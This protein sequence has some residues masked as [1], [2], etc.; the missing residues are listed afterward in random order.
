M[1]TLTLV[2]L[3]SNA[4]SSFG[5]PKEIIDH[6]IATIESRLGTT[7]EK[8]PIYRTPCFPKGAGPDY[9]NAVIR[10]ETNLEPSKILHQLHE[11]ET[12]F[13]RVRTKRWGE[14][15]LDLDL[16]CHGDTILPDDTEVLHWM[17]LPISEQTQIAPNQLILP[18]P[19]IQDRAFVLVP[20]AMV[21]PNWRHPVLHKTVIDMRDALPQ[22][23]IEE[24]VLYD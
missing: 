2:A 10:F 24:V 11:I 9:A 19:R 6:A 3:G 12:E 4:T 14:R 22:T 16:L 5:T 17:N 21:A 8:S 20:M 1:R 23:E 18:H 15:T 13:G 7:C